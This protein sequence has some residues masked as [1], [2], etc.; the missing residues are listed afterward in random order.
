MTR[1]GM[2]KLAG[3]AFA[4]FLAA[5]SAAGAAAEPFPGYDPRDPLGSAALEA[6]RLARTDI[7]GIGDRQI[8]VGVG[9]MPLEV[10]AFTRDQAVHVMGLIHAAFSRVPNIRLAP[11]RDL[12]A[13]DDIRKVGMTTTANAGNVEDLAK[14]VELVVQ[15]TGQKSGNNIRVQLIGVGKGAV[16]CH[17]LTPPI[18]LPQSAAGDVYKPIEQIFGQAARDVWDQARGF[19]QIGVEA[20]TV[21][22]RSLDGVLPGY[23]VTGLRQAISAGK[24]ERIREYA[25]DET[26]IVVVPKAVA[27]AEPHQ[28]WNGDIVVE[29]RSQGYKVSIDLNRENRTSISHYG[30]VALDEMPALRR[31]DLEK[32]AALGR[33]LPPPR[34]HGHPRAPG[35]QRA[36]GEAAMIQ[37]SA[38]PT[39]IQD[40]IDDQTREQRYAFRLERE[41]FVEFDV[42]RLSGAS[43]IVTPDLAGSDGMPIKAMFEGKARPNLRRY[44][45]MA[46][47]Y[48]LRLASE[49]QGKIEYVLS[50]RAVDIGRMLEPEAPGR[51]TRR[52][53]DW[54]AGEMRRAGR[55]VCYVYTAAMDVA[56]VGWREQRPII[57]LSMSDDPAEPLNHMLDDV[58]RYNPDRP[59]KAMFEAEGGA[60]RPLEVKALSAHIQPVALNAAGHAVLNRDAVRSYTLGTM[61]ELSGETRES[62]PAAIR[63]SLLG[64]RSAVNAAALNCGRSDLARDL[65]W[66]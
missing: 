64:Y 6:V 46:G 21:G 51:L 60:M 24:K 37:F 66:K 45:L 18:E 42:Q 48:E 41:S 62:Q 12:G 15:A 34:P 40:S 27:T 26:E 52:F 43:Q 22:G 39:R 17:F 57:W 5:P 8:V 56:P 59:V 32:V 14:D 9:S 13:I 19:N 1:K 20:R 53:Q 58:Q 49:G 16:V 30:I 31:S 38:A 28:L 2:A 55:K 23:F 63:Y 11:F 10:Q 3:A 29:P 54:Y 25:H 36:A 61:I 47:Q 65:V 35:T 33:P 4:G 44:R 7:C 50:S